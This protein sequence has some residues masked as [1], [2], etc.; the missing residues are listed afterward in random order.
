MRGSTP[1]QPIADSHFHSAAIAARG[2]DIGEILRDLIAGGG[3]PMLDV[4]IEPEDVPE[5]ERLV[6]GIAG[7]YRSVG[8]H[9]SSTN[10]ADPETACRLIES[11]LDSGGFAA[12]GETGLDWYRM[13]APKEVQIELFLFHLEAAKRYNLPVIIHN[14]SADEDVLRLLTAHRPPRG[15]VMHCFSSTPEWVDRFVELGMFVSFAGNVTFKNA[16]DL[17]TAAERVPEELLLVETDAPFLAPHPHRG[18]D[19]HPGLLV[20]TLQAVAEARKDTPEHVATVT[21][22]N[23]LK[24]LQEC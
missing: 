5:R 16:G 4:G 19:N 24:Y 9:P 13:Y 8:L 17:R 6:G 22:Q 15:G 10:R 11:H 12:V 2:I 14:R 20:H 23:L 18:R 21:S 1:I 7:V 3:G